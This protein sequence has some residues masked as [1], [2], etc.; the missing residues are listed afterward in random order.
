MQGK[1]KVRNIVRMEYKT[2][3]G[4]MVRIQYS[5]KKYKKFFNDSAHGGKYSALLCAIS[6][7]DKTKEEIGMPNTHLHVEGCAR[8][9]TGVQGVSLSEKIGKYL[10]SWQDANGRPNATSVSINKYGK[11]VAFK[12]ACAIRKRQEKW[13]LEG[14]VLPDHKKKEKIY[15]DRRKY[16][17]DELI[18]I[19]QD[20]SDEL[21][22]V[23]TSRDFKKT[24]PNYGRYESMFGGWNKALIAAGLKVQINRKNENNQEAQK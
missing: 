8:S 7:R 22:R 19:L 17:A 4:W 12:R 14:N 20:A 23:P 9:N 15:Y 6:W 2:P 13:R 11:E 24:K 10:V 3:Y 5:K 1:D 21:G 18:S 16:T